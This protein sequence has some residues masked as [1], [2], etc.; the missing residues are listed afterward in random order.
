MIK[1]QKVTFQ[2][3]Q[4]QLAE[5]LHEMPPIH[6]ISNAGYVTA[7]LTIV[8]TELCAQEAS[9][10][11]DFWKMTSCDFTLFYKLCLV[12]SI[13]DNL[14]PIMIH[15]NVCRSEEVISFFWRSVYFV[16]NLLKTI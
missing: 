9:S 6:S 12:R 16:I 8:R 3:S 5:N 4:N 11:C 13:I 14:C 15:F 10:F 1:S 7:I 2:K